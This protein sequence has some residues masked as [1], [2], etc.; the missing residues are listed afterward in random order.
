MST[1]PLTWPEILDL[2]TDP[3]KPTE[4]QA[5]VKLA[6]DFG[7]SSFE[8]ARQWRLRNFIP[9]WHWPRLVDLLEQRHDMAVSYRQLVEATIRARAPRKSEAA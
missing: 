3:A 8:V 7:L 9:I 4:K 1:S 6:D 5:A 2:W